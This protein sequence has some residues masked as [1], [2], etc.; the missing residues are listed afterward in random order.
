ME[1]TYGV[2]T[3]GGV[4]DL[5]LMKF[6]LLLLDDGLDLSVFLAYNFEKVFSENL[7]TLNLTFIRASV[8]ES[9]KERVEDGCQRHT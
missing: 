6:H 1:Y 2:S 9:S 3:V 5:C 7:R 4:L 8:Y